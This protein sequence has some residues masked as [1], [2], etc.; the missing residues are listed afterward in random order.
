MK[1]CMWH[2][3]AGNVFLIICCGI[4]LAAAAPAKAEKTVNLPDQVDAN[5]KQ[6]HSQLPYSECFDKAAKYYNVDADLL[7]SIAWH[8][9]KFNPTAHNTKNATPTED[10]GVMQI[11]SWWLS[12]LSQYGISRNELW[13]P[14]TNI[15]VGAWILSTEIARHEDMWTAVGYYNARTKW[16]RENYSSGVKQAFAS[17]K[18]GAMLAA[19]NGISAKKSATD[20]L[21][22]TSEARTLKS[23]P[24][25]A[26][27][28]EVPQVR[29]KRVVS[30]AQLQNKKPEIVVVGDS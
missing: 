18:S 24:L 7:R 17:L 30:V 23:V 16:K 26:S 13:E 21:Q 19:Y 6:P 2:R 10:I 22:K 28:Q 15:H 5:S 14:C 4:A 1:T 8:E 25:I 29:A 20:P 27:V 11:N 9:S 3:K 12:S